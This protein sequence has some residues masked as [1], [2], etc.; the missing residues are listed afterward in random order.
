MIIWHM[1]RTRARFIYAQRSVER[2]QNILRAESLA[3]KLDTGDVKTFWKQ[4]KFINTGS[5]P[6]SNKV[7]EPSG[8]NNIAGM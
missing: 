6:L 3:A 8:G 7:G 1:K 5:T 4:V 2:N